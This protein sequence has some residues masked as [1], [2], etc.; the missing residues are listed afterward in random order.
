M[1]DIAHYWKDKESRKL[2]A[3][4]HTKSMSQQYQDEIDDRVKRT[5]TYSGQINQTYENTI[6]PPITLVDMDSITAAKT[7]QEGK[8]AILNFASYKHPGGGFMNGSRAQE[9]CLC[10]DSYLYNILYKMTDY[11]SWNNKH[12]NRALYTNR[13]LYT[14]DVRFSFG[15]CDVITCASPNFTTAKKYQNVSADENNKV[16]E[17]R[18]KFILDIAANNQVDTLILG[19]FGCGV[20]SQNPTLVCRYFYKYLKN[21][22]FKKI[23]FAIPVGQYDR[24]FKA[25]K[26]ELENTTNE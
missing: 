21:Y 19:A 2:I 7:Y 10:H 11:Y 3:A 22:H 16:L 18:I 26:E 4:Q 13:G 15:F 20:F 9:E 25:F 6:M 8:T 12:L 14:P 1:G 17:E 23:V 5:K 24:N